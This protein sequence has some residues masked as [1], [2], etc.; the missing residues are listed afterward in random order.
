MIRVGVVGASGRMGREVLRAIG[1]ELSIGG[2]Y[3]RSLEGDIG[4]FLG[5]EALG[6]CFTGSLEVCAGASDLLIDFSSAEISKEVIACAVKMQKPLV[7]GTTG[8]GESFLK[9]IES[10]AETIPIFY[11]AN[12]SLGIAMMSKLLGAIGKSFKEN[13]QITIEEKHHSKKKDRPSGTAKFLREALREDVEIL[14]I[15]QGEII[16]EHRVIFQNDEEELEIKHTCFDRA[17]FAKGALQAA[18]FLAKKTPGR[19][20][21][22]DLLNPERACTESRSKISF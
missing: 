15:R 3:S 12:F 6:K 8:Q 11:A 7:M 21:M 18:A 4:L 20:T 10:A 17:L 9:M 2:V 22:F 14:S 16:G 19:Y 5:R 1:G 13:F